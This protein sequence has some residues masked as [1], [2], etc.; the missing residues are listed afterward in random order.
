MTAVI[1]LAEEV[2]KSEKSGLPLSIT[3][4]LSVLL[5]FAI[6]LFLVTRL[7]PDR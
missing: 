1:R 5:G 2:T 3:L 4:G 7:N 6:L